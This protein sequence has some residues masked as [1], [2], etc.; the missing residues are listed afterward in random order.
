[1][2]IG[3]KNQSG[4]SASIPSYDDQ[5]GSVSASSSVDVCWP[6]REPIWFKATHEDVMD[7]TLVGAIPVT[8]V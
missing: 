2:I 5:R 4:M 8:A 6:Y 1:M 3:R 7:L